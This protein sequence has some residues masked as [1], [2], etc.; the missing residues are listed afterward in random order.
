MKI[1]LIG[2]YSKL[3]N[4]L[5]DGL[6]AN[7]HQVTLVSDGDGFKKYP[8]DYSYQ[9]KIFNHKY[10]F[11]FTKLI[12]KIF[13]INLLKIE[14]FIRFYGLLPQLKNFDIVQLINE[15]SIVTYAKWEI[16]LLK[17]ILKNNKKLFLLSCGEDFYSL[18]FYLSQK[19]K[20]SILTPFFEDK[21]NKAYQH[22]FRYLEKPHLELSKFLFENCH[23]IIASDFDYVKPLI[24]NSKYLG[25]IPNPINHKNLIYKPIEIKDKVVIFLGINTLSYVKKGI[26]YFEKALIKIEEKYSEKVEIIISKNIPY[27]EYHQKM[28]KSH[29]VLDQVFALDQGYNA[30][31]CM[32]M[33][34]VVFTGAE[35]DF[36]NY[37]QLEKNSVCI[38]AA[39][40]IDE[41]VDELS[42]L[43]ENTEKIIRIGKNARNF[44]IQNHDYQSIAKKY[45]KVWEQ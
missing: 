20:Y 28:E 36:L 23:G 22:T 4:S 45:M 1:L 14:K 17:K 7:G 18:T 16:F 15:Q 34:K 35:E 42:F 32:A 5:K 10:L 3:H 12:L 40:N 29:I 27:S 38:N 41:L 31:E 26:I 9:T 6:V 33:G 24:H 25:I 21:N 44:I 39:P 8:S 37:Y 13:N 30:L 43:I 2:E 19:Q 11:F